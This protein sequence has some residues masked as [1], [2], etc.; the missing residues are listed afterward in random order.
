[1]ALRVNRA[2]TRLT[3][4]GQSKPVSSMFTLTRTCGNSSSLN[5]LMIVLASRGR[6]AARVAHH[7]VGV[8]GRRARLPV[9][10]VVVEHRREGLRAALRHREHEGLAPARVAFDA[11]PSRE[12]VVED[13][14]EL[15][16]DGPVPLRE[17]ELPFEGLRV[18]EARR[19]RDPVAAAKPTDR[20]RHKKTCR[21]TDDGTPLH[22][23][24]TLITELATRCR[25]PCRVSTDPDAPPLSL[26]T[27]PTPTQR[28]A[29]RLVEMFPVP[30][31]P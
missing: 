1:M 5:R 15:A 25:N 6:P 2:I 3:T 11:V 17:R 4:S 10:E 21:R 7:E 27:E 14:P 12:A 19:T 22:S 16:D 26:L 24:D 23:L 31:T 9:R 30:G 13:V 20:A 18:A 28:R 29:A 8:A